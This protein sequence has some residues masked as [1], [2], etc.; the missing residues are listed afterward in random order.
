[1]VSLL[2]RKGRPH[3]AQMKAANTK[4]AT[5]TILGL[6]ICSASNVAKMKKTHLHKGAK[7]LDS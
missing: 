4:V 2:E 5:T 6:K 3:K 1:M 7:H